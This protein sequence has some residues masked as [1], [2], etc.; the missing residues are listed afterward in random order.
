MLQLRLPRLNPAFR[1]YRVVQLSDLHCDNRWM[2]AERLGQIVKLA[3]EQQP[4]LMV[5]T[6]DFVTGYQDNTPQTLS[7]LHDLQARDGIFA[8]LGNHDHWSGAEKIR[9]LIQAN[10]IHELNDNVHT[11]QRA[12]GAML[13]LAGLDDLWP[14]PDSIVPLQQHLGRV[15]KLAKSAPRQRA[16]PSYLFMS[17][18]LPMLQ[19]AS[20]ASTC[21]SP[22]TRMGGRCV[23]PSTEPSSFLRSRTNILLGF[24]RPATCCIIPVAALA[25]SLHCT[26]Q[27]SARDDCV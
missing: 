5:I 6:G 9:P 16:Q 24:I 15:Q 10:G 2:T 18:I 17:R 7:V 27:L 13:H 22:G 3:N 20:D 26:A 12:N 23:S 19:L 21:N 8:I 11:I 1:G 14:V 25:C 4:D